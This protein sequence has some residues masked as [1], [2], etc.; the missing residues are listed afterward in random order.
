MAKLHPS[1]YWA[2]ILK[3]EYGIT[4]LDEDGWDRKGD[5]FKASWS[6]PISKEEFDK[7]LMTSTLYGG[8][9]NRYIEDGRKRLKRSKFLWGF[10]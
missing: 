2:D 6:E 10:G 5:N 4:I 1:Q 9:W 8:D 7:R 3:N